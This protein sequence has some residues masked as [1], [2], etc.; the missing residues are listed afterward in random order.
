[1]LCYSTTGVIKLVDNLCENFDVEVQIWS[2]LMK[3]N[4]TV[5]QMLVLTVC[6]SFLTMPTEKLIRNLFITRM[7][8]MIYM[9]M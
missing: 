7:I 1:M 4:I 8:Q 3:E 6:N 5:R 2:D 9:Y